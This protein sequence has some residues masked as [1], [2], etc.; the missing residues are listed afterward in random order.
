MA[1]IESEANRNHYAAIGANAGKLSPQA[2]VE[3]NDSSWTALTGEPGGV[4]YI[5]VD[6]GGVPGLWVVP[7][8][9]DERRVLFYAH[10]GGF[11][12]GSIYTHRK[13][14]GHLAKAVGCRALL[15]GYPL[16]PTR[17]SIRPS[18]RRR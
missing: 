13:L 18:S 4:D 14:V 7:K 10:G 6:A 16:G 8:G 9:A 17:P 5:E 12:G 2:F 15:Y 11:L 3:F 1:S